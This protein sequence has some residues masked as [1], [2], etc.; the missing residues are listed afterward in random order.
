MATN[1]A[2]FNVLLPTISATGEA[3]SGMANFSVPLPEVSGGG[4]HRGGIAN[5]EVPLIELGIATGATLNIEVPAPEIAGG[6]TAPIVGEASITVPLISLSAVSG[7][8]ANVPLPLAVVSATGIAGG[9]VT[10]A[11][12]VPAAQV[13]ATGTIPL[14]AS[15]DVNV[16]LV[17]ISAA[18]HKQNTIN[19][20]IT[21]PCVDVDISGVTGTIGGGSVSVPL[22]QV[23]AEA[24]FAPHGTAAITVPLVIV[25]ARGS[26][27][28]IITNQVESDESTSFA[29]SVNLTNREVSE[30]V[31]YQFNSQTYFAGK[32]IGANSSGLFN[33]TGD[34]DA[35][36]DIAAKI[37]TGLDDFGSYNLKRVWGVYLSHNGE[38]LR[39]KTTS[40]SD[41]FDAVGGAKNRATVS[42]QKFKVQRTKRDTYWGVQVENV[43]GSD[44][45]IGGLEMICELL[46]RRAV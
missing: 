22:V 18:G 12:T 46:N 45:E 3:R 9:I 43:R 16:P 32:Y 37:R 42:V 25:E 36:T 23:T 40:P 21:V 7:G 15:A 13:N 26:G 24:T 29:V 11:I 31:N 34:D 35:G 1:D 41:D 8:V 38:A 27:A 14:H 2:A 6:I 17:V 33:L 4:I 19:A 44:F 5:L 10:A 28:I 39:V 30:Y 20:N